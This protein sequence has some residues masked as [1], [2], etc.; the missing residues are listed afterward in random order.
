VTEIGRIDID[1]LDGLNK[2]LEP[3]DSQYFM[4]EFRSLCVKE[5]MHELKWPARDYVV[6]VARFDPSKGIPNVI[7]S[8]VRFRGLLNKN[9]D[10]R[11]E[12][13]PQLLICG[14]G[15]VD[16]PDA[17]IIYD[18]VMKQLTQEPYVQYAKDIVVM[19]IPPSDQRALCY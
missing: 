3:W 13:T 14:H 12:D 16:D 7:D 2:D 4:G 6:Q 10:R 1:R 5:R 17:S 18:E 15:A 11:E 19:R 9:G 8:Y